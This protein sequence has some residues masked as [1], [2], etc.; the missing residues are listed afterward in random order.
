MITMTTLT[1]LSQV[2]NTFLKKGKLFV[3]S[4]IKEIKFF[5]SH[6]RE[7]EQETRTTLKAL[8]AGTRQMNQLCAHGKVRSWIYCFAST[9]AQIKDQC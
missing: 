2:M 9:K 5:E 6:F 4:F 3:D 1:V 7:L 8:Q